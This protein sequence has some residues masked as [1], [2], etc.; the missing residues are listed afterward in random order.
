MRK[1]LAEMFCELNSH[2]YHIETVQFNG[3]LVDSSRNWNFSKH[4]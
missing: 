3:F 1:S 4:L 2:S